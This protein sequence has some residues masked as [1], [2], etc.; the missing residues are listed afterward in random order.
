M[1]DFI[2]SIF[3]G[4]LSGSLTFLLIGLIGLVVLIIAFALD[5]IFDAFDIGDGPLSLTTLAAFAAVFGGV[6]LV[7]ISSGASVSTAALLG[8]V[9]GLLGGVGAWLLSRF[10][11]NS[12][13]SASIDSN[14]LKG[15]TATVIL[16]ITPERVGEIAISANGHRHTFSA[17]ADD[18]ISVGTEVRIIANISGTSVKVEKIE[19]LPTSSDSQ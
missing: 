12:E 18:T 2:D 13:S 4:E 5:G 15:E 8:A 14:T 10:F 6:G 16:A 11:K 3:N 19:S 9:A 7:A 17:V 1:T